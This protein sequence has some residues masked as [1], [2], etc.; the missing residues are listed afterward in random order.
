ML[1]TLELT[2]SITIPMDNI[3]INKRLDKAVSE[4][5]A[6]KIRKSLFIGDS[7]VQSNLF[8][9]NKEGKIIINQLNEKARKMK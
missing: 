6:A 3:W 9:I 4:E 1:V 5:H 7:N 2:E 8:N